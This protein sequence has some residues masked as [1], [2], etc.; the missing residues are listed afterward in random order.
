MSPD[1]AI[2]DTPAG[3][4]A[5]A[6]NLKCLR[7]KNNA[8]IPE[9]W[10]NKRILFY[11]GF[12]SICLAEVRYILKHT[13]PANFF[14]ASLNSK[15]ACEFL[16]EYNIDSATSDTFVYYDRGNIFLR[17]EAVFQLSGLIQG[18]LANA[19]YLFRFLPRKFTDLVYRFIAANR[20]K[21]KK[22]L[23]ECPLPPQKHRFRF[24]DSQNF[25][26]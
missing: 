20:Y 17:S 4:Q 14:F 16:K 13:P 24:L 21:W 5:I 8:S 26:Q 6:I 15:F 22:K 3:T 11:D 18:K 9:P 2:I 12:C 10:R 7:L 19:I 1:H 23:E 25:K